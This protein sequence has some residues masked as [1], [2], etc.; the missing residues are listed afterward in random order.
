[1]QISKTTIPYSTFI[2]YF[3]LGHVLTAEK[4][5][6]A[7]PLYGIILLSMV[8]KIPLAMAQL[9][10]FI[11]A[12]RRIEVQTSN[13]GKSSLSISETVNTNVSLPNRGSCPWRN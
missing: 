7:I 1:M 3:W 4:V 2:V 8:Q 5:F 6:F 13:G 9:G 12:V 11:V 10:E